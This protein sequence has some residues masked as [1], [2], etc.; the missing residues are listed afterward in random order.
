MK[1]LHAAM[2]NGLCV[3][4][5]STGCSNGDAPPEQSGAPATTAA[6]P[7]ATVSPAEVAAT[8]TETA[9]APASAEAVVMPATPPAPASTEQQY[10]VECAQAATA[11]E[12]CRVDKETYVGWRTF[13]S[14]CQVCHGGSAL[15][16]TFAPNLLDR[17]HANV[18]YRRFVDVV[19]NGYRGP[20]GMMPAWKNN[21]NVAPHIDAI[22]Q[23]LKARADGALP[24][25]RPEKLMR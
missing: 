19:L 10:S 22:Y 4:V 2:M 11:A 14:Q 25:G 21:P 18:D 1:Y 24:P 20:V 9:P 6:A 13:A 12:Q 8:V 23:Y 16:T 15:G 17:L 7:E 5:L 3:A